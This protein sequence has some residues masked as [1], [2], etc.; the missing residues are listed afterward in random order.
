MSASKSADPAE[1]LQA[2]YEEYRAAGRIWGLVPQNRIKAIRFPRFSAEIIQQYLALPELTTTMSDIL[3][4]LGVHGAVSSCRILPLLPGTRLAGTAVTLR[5]VPQQKTPAQA[6][7]DG[8][9]SAMSTR[10]IYYLGEP[11][12]VLVVDA[13]GNLDFSNLGGQSMTGAKQAGFAGIVA[14]GVVRDLPTIRALDFPVWA[15][16]TT[17]ITGKF[18]LETIELNGHVKVHDVL[19]RPGDLVLADDNGLC[20]VPAVHVDEVLRRAKL[21]SDREAAV[22]ERTLVGGTADSLKSALQGGH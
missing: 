15:R 14:D 10:D 16:G 6:A 11:G 8:E 19:V 17:P 13:G 5:N 9:K 21:V 22:R 18:R 4:D 2:E 7:A 3:D 12:D 20:F 1:T